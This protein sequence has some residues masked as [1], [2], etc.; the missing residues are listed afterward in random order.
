MVGIVS[1]KLGA[2]GVGWRRLGGMTLT[3]VNRGRLLSGWIGLLRLVVRP[4]EFP[5]NSSIMPCPKRSY[6]IPN[7]SRMDDLLPLPKSLLRKPLV[8]LGAQAKAMR[9]PRL[10]RSEEHTSELQSLRH[11]VCR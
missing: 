11:L 2:P 4:K 7:P 6:T 10:P 1:G 9:G 8:L 3:L 5:L